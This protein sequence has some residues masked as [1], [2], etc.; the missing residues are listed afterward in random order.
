MAWGFL[1]WHLGENSCG[2]WGLRHTRAGPGKPLGLCPPSS[3]PL[4][5]AHLW[6]SCPGLAGK[7]SDPGLPS[8]MGN[9][10]E[11]REPSQKEAQPASSGIP[12]HGGAPEHTAHLS[13][14]PCP[15]P[16][17]W[18]MPLCG[19]QW[20]GRGGPEPL[21]RRPPSLSCRYFRLP[22]TTTTTSALAGPWVPTRE[23]L[24]GSDADSERKWAVLCLAR[25]LTLLSRPALQGRRGPGWRG[26]PRPRP[27]PRLLLPSPAPSVS[28]SSERRRRP[29]TLGACFQS[30][31]ARPPPG[32]HTPASISGLLSSGSEAQR[33]PLHPATP[34]ASFCP[35][36]IQGGCA[37]GGHGALAWGP[38]GGRPPW[39]AAGPSTM[40]WSASHASRI[41]PSC[42][43]P[44]SL[45][46][47]W[48]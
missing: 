43:R 21:P 42:P 40:H 39:A 30:P 5:G 28:D 36:T 7:H 19:G 46:Y 24:P 32:F 20:G 47:C 25:F 18:Q 38:V 44:A 15:P 8:P 11:T 14:S 37:V 48:N 4:G 26:R 13:P 1:G 17:H 22:P 3:A 2:L 33:S 31:P 10:P 9:R 41:R 29:R 34:H 45:D 27:L 16:G 12:T 6:V 23:A 35:D